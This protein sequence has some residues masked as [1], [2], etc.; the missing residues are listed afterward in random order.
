M[1]AFFACTTLFFQALSSHAQGTAFTYHGRLDDSGAP[2]TGLYD[3]R[4]D[5]HG[6]ASGGSALTVPVEQVAQPVT[7][8]LFTVTLDFGN[9]FPGAPRWLEI[10]VRTNGGGAFTTLE[11]RSALTPTPYA[12]TAG[13]VT[14]PVAA[15]QLSGTIAAGQLPPTVVTNGASG[16]SLTGTFIGDGTGVTNVD[17]RSFRQ[18][19]GAVVGW[20][21]NPYGQTDIPAGLN[22]VV[23]IDAGVS[24]SL[25]VRRDG[26]FTMWGNNSSGQTDAPLGLSNVV[27]LAGGGSHS[28]ALRRDGTVV[29][30]GD[31][32][33]NQTNVP[34]GLSGVVA[35]A[36][37]NAHN[38]ALKNDGTVVTWGR[39]GQSDFAVPEGLSNVVQVSAGGNFSLA[40][41]S[42][43][44]VV[45]W[46]NG[47]SGQTNIPAGLSNVV[48]VAG[49]EFYVL[50]LKGD[51]TVVAWGN[52]SSSQTNL[53]PGFTNVVAIA[54][55]NGHSLALKND[56][57]VVAWG[58]V[59][60]DLTNALA[61]LSNVVAIAAGRGHSL[62]LKAFTG[63]AAIAL[64][65]DNNNFQGTVTAERVGIGT[66]HPD[67]SLHVA[68]NTILDGNLTL[69]SG[70][71]V[72]LNVQ[73]AEI[74]VE[75]TAS[76]YA[77]TA[78]GFR[79]TASGTHSTALGGET[80]AGGVA[81]MSAGAFSEAAHDNTFV[82]GD[83]SSSPAKFTSTAPRQFLIQASGGVGINTNNP[84]DAAL[85][86][87]GRTDMDGGLSTVGPV[88]VSGSL[89][90]TGAVA[91]VGD[92]ALQ[93]TFRGGDPA[94]IISNGF[95]GGFIGGGGTAANPNRVGGDH[96]AILGGLGNTASGQAATA[97]GFGSK[98]SGVA[99]VAMGF[100]SRAAGNGA[101]ALGQQGQAMHNNTFVFS[102]AQD[103]AFFASTAPNQFLVRAAGGVGINTATPNG[104]A[105]A[106]NGRTTLG[107]EATISGRV[108]IGTA[109][110]SAKLTVQGDGS[111][112][113][114]EGFSSTVNSAVYGENTSANGY[115]VAGR[116]HGTGF[117]IYGHNN[118]NAGWA[119]Y[120]D[121][122]VYAGGNAAIA[123]AKYLEFGYG[124][125]GKEANAG[126]IGY[127]TFTPGTL[128]I[129]G[130]GTS[131]SDRKIKLWAE[132]GATMVGQ[133]FTVNGGSGEQAYLGADGAGGDIEIGSRNAAIM[134]AYFWNPAAGSRMHLHVQTIN[135]VSDRNAK[136]DFAPVDS[137]AMLEKVVALPITEWTYKSDVATRHVGPVA[138]DFH[139]AFGVGSSDKSISTVDADGV[140][141]AAIQ[142]LNQKL[143]G[144]L[145]RKETEIADLKARLEKLEALLLRGPRN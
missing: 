92:V 73:Q 62:A 1:L 52:G 43:G 102:D 55:G 125:A 53:P 100:E 31:N 91:I 69:S 30:W 82:W 20:G 51:G 59:T 95:V 8:G 110:P 98:A 25:A 9:Q 41:K 94:N 142:G 66:T 37:G 126:K 140:A 14:G 106:V 130:A 13:N 93:G 19:I 84:G 78:L 44:T 85:S 64:L 57:T 97:L 124:V 45:A 3:L 105:L 56:G 129:V 123:G 79:T 138:Q 42:D 83:G 10:S 67:A 11:P 12:I 77:A 17:V 76:G 101:V 134:N 115:G 132:G 121:G 5:L 47:G 88:V 74:G 143:E 90:V 144:E 26:S 122:N 96:A 36:S 50:A 111:G 28:V 145:E 108:G 72:E 133:Y 40:L 32:S 107:G 139:A 114:I 6:V 87:R 141:L 80:T 65:T 15:G 68:G 46:G 89:A 21:S 99:S 135:P 116:H 39:N 22:N 119:G 24:H 137:A 71:R 63:S 34:A 49:G 29:A 60:P 27:A 58:I 131:G 81:A 35:I 104:A 136:H 86:V 113:G 109:T 54:A 120:F 127:A 2:A 112:G 128:D 7:N 75:N 33:L 4:F 16:L 103:G 117:A 18:E 61:G 48:A 70:Q 38:L 23:A 118:N